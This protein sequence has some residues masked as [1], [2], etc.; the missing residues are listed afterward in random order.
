MLIV[1]VILGGA[2]R[3]TGPPVGAGV[4]LGLEEVLT[5][6]T[7]HWQ[8]GLGLLLLLVV[9]CA[10]GGITGLAAGRAPR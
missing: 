3:L 5:A 9:L 8:L 2:G 4:V 6:S 10:P 1:M 7:Q